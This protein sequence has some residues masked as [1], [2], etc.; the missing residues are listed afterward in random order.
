[1]MMS[2]TPL[3]GI[4]RDM[5][6]IISD[7]SGTCMEGTRGAPTEPVVSDIRINGIL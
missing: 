5:I 4:F 6:Q 3:V 1:M 7:D 2:L